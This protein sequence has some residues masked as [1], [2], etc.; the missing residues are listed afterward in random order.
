MCGVL[1]VAQRE[2]GKEPKKGF[3]ARNYPRLVN[4]VPLSL[5]FVSFPFF[6]PFSSSSPFIAVPD[7]HDAAAL[8]CS[9]A[10]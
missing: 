9:V 10:L 2:K 8:S 6:P 7:R 5:S 1:C 4:F 3:Q